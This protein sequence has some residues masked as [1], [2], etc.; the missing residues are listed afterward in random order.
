MLS[1]DHYREIQR[2]ILLLIKL[3]NDEK[4]DITIL[5]QF[6]MIFRGI[7]IVTTYTQVF[8][9]KQIRITEVKIKYGKSII[10]HAL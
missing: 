1:R 8:D 5:N 3:Y 6:I 9:N 2:V 10:T 7:G 4:I